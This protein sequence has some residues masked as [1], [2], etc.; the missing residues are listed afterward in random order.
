MNVE[1]RL[2][3]GRW[4]GDEPKF[5][6]AELVRLQVSGCRGGFAFGCARPLRL[7]GYC[8]VLL[9]ERQGLHQRPDRLEMRL[10]QVLRWS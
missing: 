4:V 8:R 6:L 5:A 3:D 1:V 9:L 7:E 10:R 2:G